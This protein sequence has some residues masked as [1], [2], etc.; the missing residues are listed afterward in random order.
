LKAIFLAAGEG[1][2]LRPLTNS[3]PKCM[4]E[5]FD[6]SLLQRNIEL[7]RSCGIDD[8]SIVTGYLSESI[9]FPDVSYFRNA[10]F[11]TTN[12][13]ETLFCARD[14]LDDS[15]II[16]YAD[17]IYEKKVLQLLINAKDE[18]SII[19]DKLWKQYWEIRFDNP[20]DDAESLII[21]GENFI[22]SVGQK[23]Q[24]ISQ[25]QGQYIG[26]MKFQNLGIKNLIDFYEKSKISSKDGINP[27]NPQLPFEKSYMTDL[28]QGL[29]DNNFKIRGIP[30][31]NGWLEVDSINDYELYKKMHEDNQLSSYFSIGD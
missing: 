31:E 24:D 12:M 18:I 9:S 10:N 11:D 1:K 14:K 27:L 22:T 25:I 17:I 19:F 30:I 8:I 5:L 3:K 15:V 6:K 21:D 16:S 4:V 26:L 20:L 13:I 7:F 23:V 29:I 28:L 2:R